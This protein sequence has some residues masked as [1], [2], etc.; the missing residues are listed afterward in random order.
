MSFWALVLEIVRL[1]F[2]TGHRR[3]GAYIDGGAHDAV[4]VVDADDESIGNILIIVRDKESFV[5]ALYSIFWHFIKALFL[6]KTFALFFFVLA[7]IQ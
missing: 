7:P 4:V 3:I 2:R 6:S 1:N 5:Y